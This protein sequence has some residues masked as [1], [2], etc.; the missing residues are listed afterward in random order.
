[1]VNRWAVCKSCFSIAG[2]AAGCVSLIWHTLYLTLPAPVAPPPPPQGSPLV[3]MSAPGETEPTLLSLSLPGAIN[4]RDC[5]AA[6]D[7]TTDDSPAFR[8]AMRRVEELG[9]QVTPQQGNWRVSGA[10]ILIPPGI[11]RL[12]ETWK[13]SRSCRI[14][15]AG[16]GL[17]PGTILLADEGVTAIRFCGWADN[18]CL[19]SSSQGGSSGSV[20]ES[21]TIRSVTNRGPPCHGISAKSKVAIRHVCVSGFSGHGVNI[22]N[23]D[24]SEDSDYVWAI[25]G[26]NAN[27][28]SIEDLVVTDCGLDGLHLRGWNANAG[29]FSGIDVQRCRWAI[30]DLGFHGNLHLG[31]HA[32]ANRAGAYRGAGS[33]WVHCYSEGGNQPPSELYNALMVGGVPGAGHVPGVPY[34][35]FGHPGEEANQLRA[36]SPAHLANGDPP[37]VAVRFGHHNQKIIQTVQRLN[38]QGQ[39]QPNDLK[40]WLDAYKGW[41]VC[42]AQSSTAH[43]GMA[44]NLDDLRAGLKG[45]EVALT[46]PLIGAP[47]GSPMI[48]LRSVRSKPTDRPAWTVLAYAEN[49]RRGDPVGWYWNPQVMDWLEMEKVK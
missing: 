2:A 43:S 14:V 1:M 31:H 11:Y 44:V 34:Q 47:D 9:P 19:L 24:E 27:L 25:G 40:W 22:D 16:G 33:V 13:V 12:S 3:V 23:Y 39:P 26:H 5:G 28:C 10:T 6:G 37:S 20:I 45:G 41:L 30:N 4:V 49:A 35:R 46:A 29:I 38:P 7:G 48:Q 18:E 42:M 21:L 32:D 15:G 8:E 36:I 17:Y